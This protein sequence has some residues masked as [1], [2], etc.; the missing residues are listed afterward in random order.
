[1]CL[2]AK[3]N[4]LPLLDVANDTSKPVLAQDSWVAT[5]LKRSYLSKLA[6]NNHVPDAIIA[7]SNLNTYP[8]K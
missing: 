7:Y 4:L 2:V 1:M 6:L 3:R 8:S 5:L